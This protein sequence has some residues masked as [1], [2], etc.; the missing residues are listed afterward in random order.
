MDHKIFV[1]LVICDD[2]IGANWY[3]NPL[4]SID[5]KCSPSLSLLSLK[6]FW[7]FTFIAGAH[8]Q[9]PNT[10]LFFFVLGFRPL[11]FRS[12]NFCWYHVKTIVHRIYSC[13]Q[14]LCFCSSFN[15]CS[16]LVSFN[17]FLLI[18]CKNYVNRIYSC[19]RLLCFC[20]SFNTCKSTL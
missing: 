8:F 2:G 12:M 16:P 3:S 19:Y 7:P 17:E 9:L 15:T 11:W 6:T 5:N 13:C 1:P 10:N 20:S 18:P 14:L 4:Y